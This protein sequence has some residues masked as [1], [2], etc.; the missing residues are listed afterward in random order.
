VHQ[1]RSLHGPEGSGHFVFIETW[2]DRAALDVHCAT[3][4]FRRLVP[5]IDAHQREKGTYIL[6][7]GF[8]PAG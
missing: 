1:L 3:E 6:M 2:P 5:Q 4:H 7:D 8:D